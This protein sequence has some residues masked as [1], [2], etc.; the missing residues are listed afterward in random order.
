M[1]GRDPRPRS[2]SRVRPAGEDRPGAAVRSR[3]HVTPGRPVSRPRRIA[4]PVRNPDARP[5]AP[6]LACHWC[7]SGGTVHP[8]HPD[9][10]VRS[11]LADKRHIGARMGR[12]T[13]RSRTPA[14]RKLPGAPGKRPDSQK[15]SGTMQPGHRPQ[16][17]PRHLEPLTEPLT[18]R[19]PQQARGNRPEPTEKCPGSGNSAKATP[20]FP[21]ERIS[22]SWDPDLI[23][24]RIFPP[25][26]I[27]SRQPHPTTRPITP[28]LRAGGVDFRGEARSATTGNL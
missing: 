10:P 23:R 18:A 22:G 5:R 21:M 12:L 13:A 4:P 6:A 8:G 7:H 17:A 28:F 2:L 1:D 15:K 26:K 25:L 27:T 14:A 9:P 24:P 19:I 3:P 20:L 11:S 16:H